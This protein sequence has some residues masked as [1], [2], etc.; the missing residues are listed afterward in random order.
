M[1]NVCLY[2]ELFSAKA[3]VTAY[4]VKSSNIY[5]VGSF[6]QVLDALLGECCRNDVFFIITIHRF[7]SML[8]KTPFQLSPCPKSP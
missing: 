8:C 5:L 4:L 3:T 6:L 7:I 1:Y 2:T